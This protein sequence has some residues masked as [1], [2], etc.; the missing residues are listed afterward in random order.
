MSSPETLFNKAKTILIDH[1]HRVGEVI[2]PQNFDHFAS[3]QLVPCHLQTPLLE[4]SV[5]KR[6]GPNYLALVQRIENP[7]YGTGAEWINIVRSDRLDGG[8]HH[9][10]YTLLQRQFID[11]AS[12]NGQVNSEEINKILLSFEKKLKK[13]GNPSGSA[14]KDWIVCFDNEA[15]QKHVLG[16]SSDPV[17]IDI[18][19]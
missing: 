11:H 6:K 17:P 9:I 12:E 2:T 14:N 18:N 7:Y 3:E 5:K 10:V 19:G 8:K 16:E 4:Y 15:F 1:G 13:K